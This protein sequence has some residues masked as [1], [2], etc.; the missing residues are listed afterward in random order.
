MANGVP[1]L[2]ENVNDVQQVVHK[3]RR[4]KNGKY[5]ILIHRCVNPNVFEKIVE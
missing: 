5:L 1:A 4:K 3:E 2:E